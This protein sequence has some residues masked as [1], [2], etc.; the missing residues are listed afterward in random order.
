MVVATKTY[1]VDAEE[2]VQAPLIADW[3]VRT[4]PH[5]FIEPWPV[6]EPT[7]EQRVRALIEDPRPFRDWLVARAKITVGQSYDGR[8]CPFATFIL[9]EIESVVPGGV[10]VNVH[11]TGLHPC[12]FRGCERYAHIQHPEWLKAFIEGVDKGARG[13]AVRGATALRVLDNAI[14]KTAVCAG[15]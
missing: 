4:R 14:A 3:P 12:Q 1:E 10:Y 9:S 5:T 2:A 8:N 6:R 15:V 7:I 11:Q 13:R